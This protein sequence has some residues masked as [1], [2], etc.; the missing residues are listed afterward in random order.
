MLTCRRFATHLAADKNVHSAS[1]RIG[2]AG[3]AR[4]RVSLE[5]F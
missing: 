1:P 5:R 3:E 4:A 2:L